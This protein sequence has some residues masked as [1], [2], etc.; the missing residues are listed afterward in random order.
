[1]HVRC[2]ALGL[3]LV[4]CV[5]GTRADE[6][7]GQSGRQ[8]TQGRSSQGGAHSGHKPQAACYCCGRPTPHRRLVACRSAT[9][10]WSN[11]SLL[12]TWIG[13]AEGAQANSCWYV[14]NAT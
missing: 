3:F 7:Q 6:L 2:E 1:M 10:F 12:M 11:S 4:S 14:S 13:G 8:A 5:Q 9:R